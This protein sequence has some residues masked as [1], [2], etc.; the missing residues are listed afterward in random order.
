MGTNRGCAKILQAVYSNSWAIQPE[1]LDGIIEFL[2]I[3]DSGYVFDAEEVQDRIGAQSGS[4][5][6]IRGG[7]Q[8][9]PLM[10]ILSK[11]MDMMTEISGGTSLDGFVKRFDVAMSDP[12]VSAIVIDVDSPGGSVYG[13][14]ETSDHVYKA[15]GIKPITAVANSLMASAAY[16]V[17]SAADQIVITP[18][19]EVGSIGVV[20]LHVDTSGADEKLGLKYTLISAGE[21]KT[22]GNAYEPLDDDARGT[23]Q[24]RVDEYYDAFLSAVARNRGIGKSEVRKSY[25]QGRVAGAREAKTLG[26]V[27]RIDGLDATI[28]GVTK[29]RSKKLAGIRQRNLA[30]AV[31]N[32][33]L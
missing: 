7:V 6:E 3:R 16:W 33:N 22:E 18:S 9:L 2:Q 24:K 29:K 23:I 25:G 19:G 26:M 17:G 12:Q 21:H 11:R 4:G 13:V 1:K 5:D 30:L 15:R 31:D 20:A 14:Q 32:R 27:D 10:G 8:V 28:F